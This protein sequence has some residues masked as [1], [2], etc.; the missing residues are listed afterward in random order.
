MLAD[1]PVFQKFYLHQTRH[2]LAFFTNS[3]LKSYFLVISMHIL[4]KCACSCVQLCVV[5]D[6]SL[7][8][9]R[10]TFI[11]A[12]KISRS[13]VQSTSKSTGTVSIQNT[14]SRQQVQCLYALVHFLGDFV[15]SLLSS[16]I[17]ACQ[18]TK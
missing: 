1:F 9:L 17:C 12:L 4:I 6:N 3:L 16:N 13:N 5:S 11:N 15:C 8:H 10:Q 14:H 7:I 2:L 18:H